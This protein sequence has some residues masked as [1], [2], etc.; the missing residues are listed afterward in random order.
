[1]CGAIPFHA[2]VDMGYCRTRI[3]W[4]EALTFDHYWCSVGCQTHT[5]YFC[6]CLTVHS[7]PVIQLM[8]PLCR[9]RG[10]MHGKQVTLIREG[11]GQDMKGLSLAVH[12]FDAVRLKVDTGPDLG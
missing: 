11:Q 7:K 12:H 8:G 3:G 10:A 4:A 5:R 6:P 1:M 9:G 2:S